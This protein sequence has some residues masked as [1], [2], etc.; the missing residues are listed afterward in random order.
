MVWGWTCKTFSPSCFHDKTRHLL[1]SLVFHALRKRNASVG[2]VTPTA[3]RQSVETRLSG[4]GTP[5]C[6]LRFV[7]NSSREACPV[8]SSLP[9]P[10]F[11]LG[12]LRQARPPGPWPGPPFPVRAL[13]PAAEALAPGPWPRRSLSQADPSWNTPLSQASLCTQA[14]S[15]LLGLPRASALS[16][17]FSALPPSLRP[18]GG[19]VQ[20]WNLRDLPSSE[21]PTCPWDVTPGPSSR[22]MAGPVSP[23]SQVQDNCPSPPPPPQLSSESKPQGCPLSHSPF[24]RTGHQP[25]AIPKAPHRG[26]EV[27]TGFGPYELFSPPHL[28][29]RLCR[30]AS[31]SIPLHSSS[32]HDAL[33]PALLWLLTVETLGLTVPSLGAYPKS[34]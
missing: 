31:A 8:L 1:L 14:A 17:G 32:S 5:S 9:R 6:R 15:P 29:F 2:L 12:P 3:P 11:P 25:S 30:L 34:H 4:P 18:P 22:V 20:S 27:T 16:S 13:T 28:A 26:L 33:E 21:V 23:E 24:P 7:L 19:L 10:R